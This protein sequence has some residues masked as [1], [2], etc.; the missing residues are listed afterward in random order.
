MVTKNYE[1]QI[2]QAVAESSAP[3]G[4]IYLSNELGIP[5]ANVGRTLLR[6]EKK[7]MVAKVANKGRA[8]TETGKSYL[9]EQSEKKSKL[10]VANELINAA[11]AD[12]KQILLEVLQV[13]TLLEGYTASCCAQFA[14]EEM[15]K[16]LEDIQFDYIYELRRGRTG[17]EQDLKFHLKIAEF[18]GNHTIA[19][20]LK[21]I[22]TNNNSH[23][24][25]TRAAADVHKLFQKEHEELIE[26]IRQRDSGKAKQEMEAHLERVL[27]NVNEY[28]SKN[29][30]G[31]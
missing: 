25:F 29:I 26:A 22:L 4:A 28:T 2:L 15:I 6:L 18:S 7:G 23:V 21:L 20:I 19:R 5:S 24:E 13:R 27:E 1:W 11:S 17:R 30:P 14:T 10:C 16:E 3:V 31:D 12:E 9:E 8:I